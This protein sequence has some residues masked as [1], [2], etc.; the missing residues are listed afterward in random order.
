MNSTKRKRVA[1]SFLLLLV[2]ALSVFAVWV[3]GRLPGEPLKVGAPAPRIEV[4]PLNG[5]APLPQSGRRVLFFFSPS[6]SHCRSTLAQLENLRV[7]HPEW[8]AGERSLS[9]AFISVAGREETDAFAGDRGW[10]TYH[11]ESRAA[12]KSMGGL[13]LPYVVLVDEGGLVRH[14]HKGEFAR[15]D[16]EEMLGSF[17]IGAGADAARYEGV[18]P[19]ATLA[20][21]GE[22]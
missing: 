22:E 11:D 2:L 5:A 3:F 10:P 17:Y 21:R 6:C 13:V 20:G 7:Q 18:A 15:N 14:A 4:A 16:L 19:S 1:G 12:I 9:W 8:F